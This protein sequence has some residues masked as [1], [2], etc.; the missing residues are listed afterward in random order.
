MKRV[1]CLLAVLVM[2][3][4]P[5]GCKNAKAKAE[6]NDIHDVIRA[7]LDIPESG[8]LDVEYDDYDRLVTA[9]SETRYRICGLLVDLDKS[10]TYFD[11]ADLVIGEEKIRLYLEKNQNPIDGEYVEVVGH[12]DITEHSLYLKDCVITERG[13]SVRERLGE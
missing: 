11:T 13:A 12:I 10:W 8:I 5:C 3:V 6:P 1:I 9:I 7:F 4:V 2:V